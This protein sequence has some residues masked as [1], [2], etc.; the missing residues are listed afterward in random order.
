VDVNRS[1]PAFARREIFIETPP[2]RVWTLI[3][4]IDRWSSWQPDISTARLIGP[5]APGSTFRWKSAGTGIFSTIAEVDPPR[6]IAWT[7][8]AMGAKAKHVWMLEPQGSGTVVTT[9]ESFEGLV[10]WLLKKRMQRLLDESLSKWL[11]RLKEA[12]EKL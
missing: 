12:A 6:R 11:A 1:A 10:V 7:G 3:S 4:E 9:Q 2:E 8:R 5:L